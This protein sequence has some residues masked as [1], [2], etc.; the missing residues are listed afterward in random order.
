MKSHT[1]LTLATLT[2]AAPAFAAGK[3]PAP[4]AKAPETVKASLKNA[5]GEPVGDVTLEQTPHGVL[6]KGTLSNLS[7][8]THAI[9]IHEAGKCDA[10][11]FKTAGGHF[12]PQKKSHGMLSP[13]GKHEGDLPN[14]IVGQDGKAQFEF[15]ANEGLTVK[16]LMDKDGSAI[17]VHAQA[18]D[19]KSDPAGNAGG[20]VA[21]GVVTQ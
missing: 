14:I 19:Y 9:H 10:P 18:D 12:N 1:L 5:K 11:D 21:C 2:L 3:P 8:G 4:E 6:I 13:G 17:V 15:F 16:S 7:A 20:R